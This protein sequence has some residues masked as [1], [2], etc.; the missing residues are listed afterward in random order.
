MEERLVLDRGQA[1]VVQEVAEHESTRLILH[2]LLAFETSMRIDS[3]FGYLLL[4]EPCFGILINVF[5]VSH[6]FRVIHILLVGV[7][8]VRNGILSRLLVELSLH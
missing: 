4:L 1:G 3:L 8:L 2:A 5:N 6:L 7:L